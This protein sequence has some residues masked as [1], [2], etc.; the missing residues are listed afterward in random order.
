MQLPPLLPPP[1]PPPP[2]PTP[3]TPS[4]PPPLPPFP[5]S[6]SPSSSLPPPPSPSPSPFSFS[7]SRYLESEVVFTQQSTRV[8]KSRDILA[9][10]YNVDSRLCCVVGSRTENS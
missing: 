4:P 7:S 9:G 6:S 3:P 2:L 5:P 8:S 10:K 1:S